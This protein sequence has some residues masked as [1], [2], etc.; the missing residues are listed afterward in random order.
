MTVGDG[1]LCI[2][3]PDNM[4]LNMLVGNKNTVTFTTD[5]ILDFKNFFN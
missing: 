1:K 5:D 4:F 2:H 3:L